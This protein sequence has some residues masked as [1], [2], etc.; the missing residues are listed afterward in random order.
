LAAKH[1]QLQADLFAAYVALNTMESALSAGDPVSLR[2]G[3][4]SLQHALGQVESDA[5]NVAAR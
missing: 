4:E 3:V 2:T 5:A 1:T